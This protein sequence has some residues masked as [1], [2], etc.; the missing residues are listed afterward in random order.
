MENSLAREQELIVDLGLLK[1]LLD[2]P[3]ALL[4]GHCQGTKQS[5]VSLYA[6]SL[7]HKMKFGYHD[8]FGQLDR[9]NLPKSVVH[10]IK[11]AL[12]GPFGKSSVAFVQY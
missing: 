10:H 11:K 1:C 2:F 9:F 4:D 5:L 3:E 12:Y 6:Y 8:L 7:V